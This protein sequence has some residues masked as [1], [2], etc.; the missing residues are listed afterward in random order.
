[1]PTRSPEESKRYRDKYKEEIKERKHLEY[2]KHKDAYKARARKSAKLT[3]ATPEGKRKKYEY[4]QQWI[5][6][7][8]SKAWR[9]EYMKTYCA[10]NREKFAE[11]ERRRQAVIYGVD[12]EKIDYEALYNASPECFYCGDPLERNEVHYDH[13]VPLNKGGAHIASNIRVACEFCN[14]SKHDKLPEEFECTNITSR[15]GN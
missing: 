4:Q 11:Y 5:Q 15:V 14:L 7:P 10:A 12:A 13:Y 3:L 2:L 8:K 1:M 6:T 9:K